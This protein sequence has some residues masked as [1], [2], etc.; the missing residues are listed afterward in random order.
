VDYP[1]RIE[2]ERLTL[3]RWRQDDAD[4]YATIWADPDV[5]RSLAGGREADP[6]EVANEAFPRQLRYW[7]DR[8]FGL[9]AA[10][11]HDADGPVGWIGAW[12]QDV[13]PALNGEIEVGWALRR[14]W[15]GRGLATEGASAAIETAFEHL[16]PPRV[17]SLIHLQNE[18]S[19]AVAARLGMTQTSET[20]SRHGIPL[21][22]WSLERS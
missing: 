8:D 5:W 6:V 7:A 13:A 16:G 1:E 20:A 2:T 22:V 14:P 11:P 4:A 3:R 21:R 10:I 15:W 17:I 19:A 9:W 18:R 12:H